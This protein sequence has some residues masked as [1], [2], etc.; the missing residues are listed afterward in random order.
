MTLLRTLHS[1][2]GDESQAE[3][4]PMSVSKRV[5]TP[6]NVKKQG[7]IGLSFIHR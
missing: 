2:K 6:S 4:Q 5:L 7:M 3:C 1:R